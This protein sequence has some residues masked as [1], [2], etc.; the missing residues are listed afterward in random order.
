ML[1]SG[2]LQFQTALDT[3]TARH[4]RLCP[5]QVL[6]VRIGFAGAD[7]LGLAGSEDDQR[8]LI[9]VETDGCFADGLEAA[10]GCSLGHRTMRL[11][12]LGKVAATFVDTKT[13]A[14]VRLAP[15]ATVR[16]RAAAYSDDHRRYYQQLEG[17]QAMPLK[18][19]LAI[20]EVELNLD[21]NAL[22]GRK[23]VRAECAICHEEVL[24]GRER[25]VGAETYCRSC[26]GNS[27]VQPADHPS[28]ESALDERI[29]TIAQRAALPRQLEVPA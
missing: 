11:E 2:D 10:T 20:T 1:R 19:L 13:G 5:R 28:V 21:V 8:L 12:D 22:V 25:L 4:G 9:F 6:G 27:Y 15:R 16:Q 17:Y 7:A 24:N 3:T 14:A 23:G 26:L 29:K 18:E